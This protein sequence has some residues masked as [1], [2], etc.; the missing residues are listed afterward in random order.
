MHYNDE[1]GTP[2]DLPHVPLMFL[3]D[4]LLLHKVLVWEGAM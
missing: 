2:L 3:E 4:A 1:S